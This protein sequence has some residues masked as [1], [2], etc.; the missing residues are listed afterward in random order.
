MNDEAAEI[1]GL[2]QGSVLRMSGLIDNVMDFARGRL[3]GG[4]PIVRNSDEPLEPALKQVVGELRA[5]WPG[6]AIEAEFT[7]Q[8]PVNCDR[9]RLAQLFS[10]LLGNAL[11][12]G[13]AAE[14]VRVSAETDG[15]WFELSVS[16]AGDAIP[17]ATLQRVFLPF[18]RG[19]IRPDQRGLGL[20]LYI[21][22]LY[23]SPSPRD[24]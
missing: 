18:A 15:A 23:T 13:T 17:A 22:L 21:C 2:M 10:N 12:Y 5:G 19:T 20:G 8:D 14:P 7:L 24:R 1:L 6:R 16:N 11:A 3:G 4:I 9:G